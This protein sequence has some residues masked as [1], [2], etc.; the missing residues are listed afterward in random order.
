MKPLVQCC[1]KIGADYIK[2]WCSAV[3]RLVRIMQWDA[4]AR[5]ESPRWALLSEMPGETHTTTRDC[6]VPKMYQISAKMYYAHRLTKYW[7]LYQLQQWARHYLV[8]NIEHRTRRPTQGSAP[9]Q[10]STN[11]MCQYVPYQENVHKYEGFTYSR[12]QP[13]H[14]YYQASHQE[15]H[16]LQLLC[17]SLLS[18]A[19][20]HTIHY[21]ITCHYKL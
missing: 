20:H 17:S 11:I 10:N 3:L 8:V 13:R 15:R 1:V 9:Y 19:S 6:I 5:G 4:R 7:G 21:T 2:P 12:V 18:L 16:A 14:R